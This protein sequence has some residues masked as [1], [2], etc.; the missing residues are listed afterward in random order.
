M[1]VVVMALVLMPVGVVYLQH[2]QWANSHPHPM[3][4]VC[5]TTPTSAP[6]VQLENINAS[7]QPKIPDNK[8]Q[9]VR[10]RVQYY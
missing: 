10:S 5:A 1:V 4:W 8:N 7:A 9:P 3:Q 2:E 6:H